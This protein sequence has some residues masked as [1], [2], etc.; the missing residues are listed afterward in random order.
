MKIVNEQSRRGRAACIGRIAIA[1][2]AALMMVA[3]TMTFAVGANAQ[4]AT[5][6]TNVALDGYDK[7]QVLQID[8]KPY[9]YNGIQLRSDKLHTQ[10]GYSTDVP[11]EENNPTNP[12]KRSME[13]IFKQ[14]ADDG[15]NTVNVQILWSDL[16]PDIVSEQAQTASATISADGSKAATDVL[17]TVYDQDSPAAQKLGVL[18]FDIPDTVRNVDGSKIRLYVNSTDPRSAFAKD[19]TGGMYYTHGLNVYDAGTEADVSGLTWTTTGL[20]ADLSY[21]GTTL[22][23]GGETIKPSGVLA[24]W[25]P[26][27]RAYYYDVDVTDAVAKAK[28]DGRKKITFLLAS[29]TEPTRGDKA[30]VAKEAISFEPA[31]STATDADTNSNYLKRAK[32]PQL[33]FSDGESMNWGKYDKLFGYALKYGLNFEV[34]WFGSDSTSTN[35]D[36]R[37]PFYVYHNYQMMT[38]DQ[39]ESMVNYNG[40]KGYP[41]V[42]KVVGDP[43][44]LYKFLGDRADRNLMVKEGDMLESILN[45][46]KEKFGDQAAAL[47]G[48]QTQNEP[49]AGGFNG[50]MQ[51]KFNN[52]DG[53]ATAR[54]SRS[55]QSLALL[56]Q[57]KTTGDADH[58]NHKIADDSEFGRYETWYYN[59]YLGRRVKESNLPVWTRVNHPGGRTGEDLTAINEQ[60]RTETG[61][62]L[63]FV[64]S[65][66][67]R[68]TDQDMYLVGHA[69][70][71]NVNQAIGENLPSVMEDGMNNSNIAEKTFA[72]VAGGA[73][74][75]GYNACSFDGD[76][77]YDP[78]ASAACTVTDDPIDASDPAKYPWEKTTMTY[79]QKVDRLRLVNRLYEKVGYDLATKQSDVAGGTRLAFLNPTGQT[80]VGAT[81]SATV[82]GVD[83]TYT[84]AEDTTG[85]NIP[86]R[87]F[88]I[89]RDNH[90][91]ALG[92]TETTTFRLKGYASRQTRVELGSYDADAVANGVNGEYKSNRSTDNAWSATGL[93]DTTIDGDDLIVTV[94]A[95]DVVRI[96]DAS[97]DS[98]QG[99]GDDG[100]PDVDSGSADNDSGKNPNT[101]ASGKT[102]ADEK[103]L[104]DSGASVMVPVAVLLTLCVAGAAALAMKARR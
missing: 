72:T 104:P 64:G 89:D 59:D 57:W 50:T 103:S 56:K 21:D 9:Y 73:T 74:H 81:A 31:Q 51:K 90:E 70:A 47:I 63:D 45:H 62:H 16:Q 12:D 87:G 36:F 44:Y 79:R 24:K 26:L 17:Q 48:V 41:V 5:Q 102:G 75:N 68:K 38:V 82:G 94:P 80:A 100:K 76:A 1:A 18:Q 93:A 52:K 43:N 42:Q 84:V 28:R 69:E 95:G 20:G 54:L 101:N 83:V 39:D 77:L 46:T 86:S 92:T 27:K 10:L 32:R 85:F 37:V 91:L 4:T 35:S 7:H 6:H 97:D 2:S 34:I 19:K 23:A 30:N 22:K 60:M 58:A 3:G 67:Y 25:D 71:S 88:V 15:F 33:F 61:T 8:G 65:D 11:I 40:S 14:I 99:N 98:G 49:S 66:W 55:P 13:A 29:S 53:L 96:T 78:N